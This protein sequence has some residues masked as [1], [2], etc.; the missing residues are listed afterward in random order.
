[1]YSKIKALE[2]VLISEKPTEPVLVINNDC[3][4][5]AWAK[6]TSLLIVGSKGADLN[7]NCTVSGLPDT[8]PLFQEGFNS[9]EDVK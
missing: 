7:L 1:M 8:N 4:Y 3:E 6:L 5:V 2:V 9:K